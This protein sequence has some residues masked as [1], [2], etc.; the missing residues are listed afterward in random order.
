MKCRIAN[1]PGEYAPRA[2]PVVVGRGEQLRVIEGVPTQVCDYC[3][4]TYYTLETMRRLEALRETTA[5]PQRLVPV[6]D[7][8]TA[9]VAVAAEVAVP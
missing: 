2:R 1:C 5:P 3:G 8:A 7:F 6:Y 9:E 4:D